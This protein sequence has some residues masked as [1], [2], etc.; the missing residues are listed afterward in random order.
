MTWARC[1]GKKMEDSDFQHEAALLQSLAHPH[2]AKY[3][4]KEIR[5]DIANY[6]VME[7]CPLKDLGNQNRLQPLD[8]D[9]VLEVFVQATSALQY[10]HDRGITHRDLKPGNILVRAREPGL[11]SIALSD[12]GLAI[13]GKELMSSSA[14]GTYVF[15]A[16]EVVSQHIQYRHKVD[17]RYNN[18]ADIWSMGLVA[19]DLLL[20][21]GLPHPADYGINIRAGE[22]D[23]R[24]ASKMLVAR[25]HLLAIMRDQDFARLVADMIQWDPADRPSALECAERAASVLTALKGAGRDSLLSVGQSGRSTSPR[26]KRGHVQS[27]AKPETTPLRRRSDWTQ[28]GGAQLP[29]PMLPVFPSILVAEAPAARR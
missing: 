4:C 28:R 19:L 15:M 2:I 11:I 5:P 3:I 23:Q 21:G 27:S 17:V 25:D 16:P 8:E 1:A 26:A 13:K 20:P 12:F 6:L 14:C 7:V 9:E 18:K 10:L 29:T 22:P 24:Y